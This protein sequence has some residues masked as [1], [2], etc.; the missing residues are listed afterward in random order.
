MIQATATAGLC[1]RE[2]LESKLQGL[3]DDASGAYLESLAEVEK[4]RAEEFLLRAQAAAEET[5]SRTLDGTIGR[6]PVVP[7]VQPEDVG[8]Q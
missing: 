8:A 3:L 1:S 4:V 2:L 6:A 7:R 5:W